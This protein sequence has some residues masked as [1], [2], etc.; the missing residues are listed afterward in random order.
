MEAAA[1]ST[2]LDTCTPPADLPA[3]RLIR[4]VE[5]RAPNPVRMSRKK[6][7]SSRCSARGAGTPTRGA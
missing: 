5:D 3:N 6:A 1:D 7:A 2:T 4:S